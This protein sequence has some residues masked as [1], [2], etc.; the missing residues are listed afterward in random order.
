[1]LVQDACPFGLPDMLDAF[2]AAASFTL[3][4]LLETPNSRALIVKT[5]AKRPPPQFIETAMLL[6]PKISG[7]ILGVA[8]QRF[9]AFLDLFEGP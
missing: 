1:M 5:P 6:F 2:Q 8:I 7:L 3:G 4:A 9:I